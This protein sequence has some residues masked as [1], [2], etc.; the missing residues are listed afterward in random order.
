MKNSAYVTKKYFVKLT[1]YLVIS[2]V[3]RYFHEIAKI[4]CMIDEISVNLIRR[5]FFVLTCIFCPNKVSAF[6]LYLDLFL[7][8]YCGIG[9]VI[10]FSKKSSA[11][12][13]KIFC[14][15]QKSSDFSLL[16]FCFLINGVHRSVIGYKEAN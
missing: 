12:I 6:I 14:F 4:F 13:K 9:N 5:F 16:A 10:A 15:L 8:C 7:E 3:R 2:L 11:F 1:V